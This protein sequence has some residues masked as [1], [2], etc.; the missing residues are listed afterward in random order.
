MT[1]GTPLNDLPGTAA[2][3]P[4][5]LRQARSRLFQGLL[6]LDKSRIGT[7]IL[8]GIT[9]A[10]LG[11]PAVM[12]Y[13]RI[14]GTPVITGLYTMLLPMVVFAIFG[15]SRHLVVGADS[16][17]AALVA[18]ALAGAAVASNAKYVALTSLVAL[19][20]GAMLLVTRVL[21][22]GFIADFLSRTVLVGFLSGVGIQIATGQLHSI[23]GVEK[24]GHGS[25]GELWFTIAQ[26][27]QTRPLSLYISLIV[28]TVIVSGEKFMP[29]FPGALV[30]VIGMIAA[31]ARFHWGEHG[32]S[33]VGVVPSGLPRISVPE[34]S[35]NDIA[36]I[37]PIS[38]SCLVVI[39]AQS[40]AT[41]RAYALRYR[42]RFSE[43]VDLVG[44]SLAN[45]A[46]GSSGTFVVNGSPTKTA[47]V[48]GAGGRSQVAHLTTAAV[49]VAVLL[50]LT[51]PLSYLPNAVL[52][53]IVFLIGLKLID[54]SALIDIRRKKPGEFALA[55]ATAAAVVFLGVEYGILLAMILSL[56]QHVRQ[57]Y[58]PKSAVILHDPVEHWRMHPV[59]PGKMIEPGV[60]LYW[61][62]ADLYYA[63]A[64]YF[65][66]QA[67]LLVDQSPV[68]LRY[69]VVDSE[70]ITSVDFSAGR[71]LIELQQDLA[72]KGVTL[73][74]T[75]VTP[76]LRADLDGL[77]VTQAIRP[78]NI[79]QS[80]KQSLEVFRG[81]KADT[82]KKPH[83]KMYENKRE[84]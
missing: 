71:S 53:T 6:P 14:I 30:A 73:V 80:R 72:E 58:R 39:L 66:E 29:R 67:H 7:D 51:R 45:F 4:A 74:L 56:L 24:G 69:L 26:I 48:D 82:D 61:F 8:A 55:L 33:V 63:N 27:P 47:I 75:R 10:T 49:V 83:D 5:P 46:A 78:E 77:D 15:S 50:F 57:G 23:L 54:L 11:I 84:H 25:V 68:P 13:T 70:A 28:L 17:T 1:A 12:G 19:G 52:S 3:R 76:S 22:F 16:A 18:A 44:L 64:N 36:L 21:R 43:N 79:F 60:V 41:S 20:V 9:L 32:L 31:S 37:L 42:E 35:W 2:T 65:V 34:A 38:F 81:A 59:A 62:G 40:A